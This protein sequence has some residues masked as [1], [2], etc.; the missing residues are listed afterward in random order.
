MSTPRPGR[1]CS[2]TPTCR[3]GDSPAVQQPGAAAS[4]VPRPACSSCSAGCTVGH[5][6]PGVRGGAPERVCQHGSAPPDR[7]ANGPGAVA[8]RRRRTRIVCPPEAR[9]SHHQSTWVK[10]R[11]R[12]GMGS[13]ITPGLTAFLPVRLTNGRAQARPHSGLPPP[14]LHRPSCLRMSARCPGRRTVSW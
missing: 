9:P 2:A 5:G 1:R 6:K 3:N 13:R 14:R 10:A 4:P 8:R 11:A 7:Q 12:A